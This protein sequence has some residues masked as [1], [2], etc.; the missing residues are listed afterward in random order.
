[1]GGGGP[2]EG[3]PPLQGED[4]S[5]HVAMEENG[6]TEADRVA[7]I[8][9]GVTTLAAFQMLEE[10][11]FRAAG[12]DI[13]VRR[14]SVP[15]RDLMRTEGASISVAGQ[16]KIVGS[17][18]TIDRLH[19]MNMRSIEMLGLTIMDARN[20]RAL[21]EPVWEQERV[22]REQQRRE[23]EEERLATA[24]A[25]VATRLAAVKA[26]VASGNIK[27]AKATYAALVQ[28][29]RTSDSLVIIPFSAAAMGS[30]T[31][32]NQLWRWRKLVAKG[33]V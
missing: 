22:R 29:V 23:Q 26:A 15:L 8:E 13:K 19:R 4:D 3:V 10:C 32:H 25:A 33:V 31:A 24:K 6:L 28:A 5:L 1:M 18:V 2:A 20:L 11:D 21:L 9:G 16:A 12:I 17:A 14:Q 7:L 27:E 30:V